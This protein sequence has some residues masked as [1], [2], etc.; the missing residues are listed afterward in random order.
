MTRL[1]PTTK[2]HAAAARRPTLGRGDRTVDRAGRSAAAATASLAT[3]RPPAPAARPSSRSRCA[4]VDADA[5]PPAADRGARD[6][7]R[8]ARARRSPRWWVVARRAAAAASGWARPPARSPRGDLSRR[9]EPADGRTEVGRLGLALNAMLG[10]IEER[11]RRAAGERGAAAPVRRRR[12]AR[13]AHAAAVDP[14]LRRAVPHRRRAR[15]RRPREGDAPDRGE[16][17]R[18]GVLVDDL[19]MLARLDQGRA[20]SASRSTWRA[21]AR[22][23]R[24]RPRDRARPPDRAARRRRG[25]RGDVG[26]PHQ[27]RQ[28]LANLLRNALVHTPA[29]TPIEVSVAPRRRRRRVL[30]VRDHGPGLPAGDPARCSSA[31]GAPSRRARARRPAPASASRSSPRRRA[32][33]A[34]VSRPRT[35]PAA[36]RAFTV[37]LPLAA[38]PAAAPGF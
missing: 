10:Q 3:P 36:A 20:P 26:D 25:R 17:A 33:T 16:A 28:V 38:V 8:A 32:P 37:R 5:R 14:R 4:D 21:R 23:R 7:R 11:V 9:V 31:S 29:G 35:R 15:A 13:A 6:R 18:M 22:R 27:L 19:L 30:E 2:R 1:R 12:L 34:A 24:R